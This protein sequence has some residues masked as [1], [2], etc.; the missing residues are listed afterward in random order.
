MRKGSHLTEEHKAKL[1]F[2]RTDEQKLHCSQ[3]KMGNKYR[4]GCKNSAESNRKNSMAHKKGVYAGKKNGFYGKHHTQENNE[5]NRQAHLGRK[6]SEETR[7]K[8][9]LW[10]KQNSNW[11]GRRHTEE[12]KQKQSLVKM[13]E[14]NPVWKNG[15]S[16]A[17]YSLEWRRSLKNKI[18]QRDNNICQLCMVNIDELGVGWAT[19]HIDYNKD[20]CEENNLILLC[21]KCHGKTNHT[22]RDLWMLLFEVIL[23]NRN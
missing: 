2:K 3:A 13:G 11:K 16:F 18:R 12:S 4:L 21:K 22:H 15:A 10:H 6:H 20:N 8:M 17:P 9:S 5:I 19:H 23:D 14:N 7:R 1:R